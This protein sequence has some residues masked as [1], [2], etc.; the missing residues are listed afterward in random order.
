MGTLAVAEFKGLTQVR[1]Q[2]LVIAAI[3]L[4]KV[5]DTTPVVIA[6]E[7]THQ[8]RDTI[9]ITTQPTLLVNATQEIRAAEDHTLVVGITITPAKLVRAPATP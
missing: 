7:L 6:R 2:V 1:A 4:V 5:V 8:L 9:T 3:A